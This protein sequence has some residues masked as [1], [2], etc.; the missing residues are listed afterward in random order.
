MEKVKLNVSGMNCN[1]CANRVE[2]ALTEV[3]GVAKAKVNLNKGVAQ[4]K[5]DENIQQVDRL[6]E[7]VNEAGYQA[8]LIQ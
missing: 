2:T 3:E 1:H 8:E 4:V 7:A 6:I 5:Y